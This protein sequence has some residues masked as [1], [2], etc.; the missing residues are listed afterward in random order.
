[1]NRYSFS[2]GTVIPRNI[3]WGEFLR[4]K[5]E[6]EP[7]QKSGQGWTYKFTDIMEER[8]R[9]IV[10]RRNPTMFNWIVG[11]QL[12]NY[13]SFFF[14]GGMVTCHVSANTSLNGHID[15]R[16]YHTGFVFDEKE[17]YEPLQTTRDPYASELY[18]SGADMD[19]QSHPEPLGEDS[20]G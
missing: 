15:F 16:A 17:I 8:L 14:E 11:K 6:Y 13:A 9:S 18:R 12:I 20:S 7:L 3:M 5:A 1:M 2:S 19:R 4:F 10:R